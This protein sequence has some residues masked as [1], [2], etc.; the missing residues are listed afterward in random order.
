MSSKRNIHSA[1]VNHPQTTNR[2]LVEEYG[3]RGLLPGASGIVTREG[4]KYYADPAEARRLVEAGT[5]FYV[6]DR[7]GKVVEEVQVEEK[8]EKV[9]EQQ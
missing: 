5:V 7:F 4:N 9:E 1:G 8:N 2:V 6:K 3:Q